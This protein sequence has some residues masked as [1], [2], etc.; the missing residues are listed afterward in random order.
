MP[1][2]PMQACRVNPLPFPRAPSACLYPHMQSC[3]RK[4]QRSHAHMLHRLQQAFPRP[5]RRS[6][7]QTPAAAARQAASRS[8]PPARGPSRWAATRPSCTRGTGSCLRVWGGRIRGQAS[9][10]TASFC[11]RGSCL[12]PATCRG[13]QACMQPGDLKS[14]LLFK[15]R[16]K[17]AIHRRGSFLDLLWTLH[18]SAHTHP[19]AWPA[20]RPGTPPA[21]QRRFP[22]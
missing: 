19:C 5:T 14:G 1:L 22:A 8:A 9:F 7:T 18:A 11:G 13:V 21:A 4:C 15:G 2:A 17:G 12:R 16:P 10:R 3:P 6:R 20:C